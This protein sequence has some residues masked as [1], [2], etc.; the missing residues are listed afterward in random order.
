[1]PRECQEILK[2]FDPP[3]QVV[4]HT[5]GSFYVYKDKG[6]SFKEID[7]KIRSCIWF[8]KGF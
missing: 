7:G 5:G 3:Q 6:F 2:T 1:M 4:R 8:E